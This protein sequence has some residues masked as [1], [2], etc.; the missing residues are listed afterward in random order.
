MLLTQTPTGLVKNKTPFQVSRMKDYGETGVTHNPSSETPTKVPVFNNYN[1]TS[2]F[3]KY[4][5]F[6]GC[7]RARVKLFMLL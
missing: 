5:I 7:V 6:I 1:T 3:L 2:S 4:L